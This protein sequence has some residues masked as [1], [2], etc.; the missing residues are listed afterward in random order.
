MNEKPDS[1]W[2]VGIKFFIILSNDTLTGS[3]QLKE[4]C[5]SCCDCQLINIWNACYEM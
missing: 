2:P 3:L 1:F 5:K 4:V